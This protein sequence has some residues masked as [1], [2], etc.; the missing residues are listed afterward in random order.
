MY[1]T[2]GNGR[3]VPLERLDRKDA[4]RVF[5]EQI[6]LP[7][8]ATA[9]VT[10]APTKYAILPVT[11]TVAGISL[12]NPQLGIYLYPTPDGNGPEAGGNYKIRVP[13][14]W[15]TPP[16]FETLANT[17][18]NTTLT[19]TTAGSGSYLAAAGVPT[20]GA[21]YNL[22]VSVRGAGN[23]TGVT[24]LGRDT[25]IC[26][27]S[28]LAANTATLSSAAPSTTTSCQTFF[29]SSNWMILHWPNLII[30]GVMREIC[31][32]Y[33]KADLVQWFEG[34]F[35]YEM[36]KL[37]AY[38]FD[39]ARGTEQFAAVQVGQTANVLRRQDIESYLD[40]RGSGQS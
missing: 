38:E 22:L 32:Y 3:V 8:G 5:G 29:N 24:A 26:S 35:Q 23:Q 7:A 37:R 12:A 25:H 13:G 36:D 14:Y 9:P 17:A 40:I 27:W 19:F 10:G 16:I 2:D 18:T 11:A 20:S 15:K 21:D 33:L 30:Y 31:A 28:A 34:R 4:Q 39:R 6:N 1:Y